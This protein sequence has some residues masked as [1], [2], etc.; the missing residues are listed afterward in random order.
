MIFLPLMTI[1]PDGGSQVLRIV[2]ENCE[3][4]FWLRDGQVTQAF[5]QMLLFWDMLEDFLLECYFF[6]G[7]L[8][9]FTMTIP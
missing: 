2:K 9:H 8:F 4:Q 7:I 5:D 3:E 1:S 6:L